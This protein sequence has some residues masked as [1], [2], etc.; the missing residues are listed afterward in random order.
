MTL[1]PRAKRG[2]I[3]HFEAVSTMRQYPRKWQLV[4]LFRSR[5][6]VHSAAH[7]IE[8]NRYSPAYAKGKFETEYRPEDDG[9]DWELWA[10][11]VRKT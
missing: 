3:D 1:G 10:R 2:Q 8:K 6:S 9:L 5:Q 4:G 11:M 7:L